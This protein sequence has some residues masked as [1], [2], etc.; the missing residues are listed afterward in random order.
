ME[1]DDHLFTN[2]RDEGGR[3]GLGRVGQ[4]ERASYTGHDSRGRVLRSSCAS[5]VPMVK[6][7]HLRYRYHGSQ[8]RRV[9]GPRFRRVF[10]QREVRPAVVIILQERLDMPVK[11]GLVEDHHMIQTLAAKGANHPFD[12]S[13]LPRRARCR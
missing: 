7:A 2:R 13:S 3:S 4:R 12:E 9:H 1:N 8:L 6:T 11:G 5:L 10:A